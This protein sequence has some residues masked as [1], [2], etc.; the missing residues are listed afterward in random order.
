M[1]EAARKIEPDYV[2]RRQTQR[3]LVDYKT[4]IIRP[5]NLRREVQLVDISP[6]GF[7]AKCGGEQFTRGESV[8][9]LLPLIGIV[10]GRVMWS[11]RGCFGAQF[12]VPVDARAYLD[13]LGKLNE[14]S[15]RD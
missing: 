15:S 8:S 13:C 1:T 5:G 14:G 11:L 6:L 7:H 3:D 9:L 2:Q 12:L 10:K 4:A